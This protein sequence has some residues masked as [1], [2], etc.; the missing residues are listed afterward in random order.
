[1][2]RPELLLR[3]ALLADCHAPTLA[4][5]LGITPQAVNAQL[6]RRGERWIRLR[7]ARRVTERRASRLR[8]W[9][10]RR[11]ADMGIEPATLS[12]DDPIWPAC[13]RMPRG[14]HVRAVAAEMRA[15]RP[16]VHLAT[17]DCLVEL[18]ERVAARIE[19]TKHP[20]P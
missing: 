3:L 9:W 1:M 7:E 18:I 15:E 13:H 12:V 17:D 5:V 11:L 4:G 14:H 20:R 6:R 2:P 8:H 10:R 19:A 16:G